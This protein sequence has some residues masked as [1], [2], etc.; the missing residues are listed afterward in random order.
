MSEKPPIHLGGG[1]VRVSPTLLRRA[2]LILHREAKQLRD[3]YTVAG[4]GEWEDRQAALDH[5]RYKMCAIDLEEAAR[6]PLV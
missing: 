4:T 5:Q 2:A 1:L 3:S 6:G